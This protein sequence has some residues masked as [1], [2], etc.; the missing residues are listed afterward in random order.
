MSSSYF[1]LSDDEQKIIL[2]RVAAETGV[3]SSVVEKDIYVCWCLEQLF[4]LPSDFP[5]L[6]FKGG[7]SLSK[8]FNAIHRFS[9]DVDITVDQT[10]FLKGDNT[11]NEG[12]SKTKRTKLLEYLDTAV[13]TFAKEMLVPALNEGGST[14]PKKVTALYSKHQTVYVEYPTVTS[15]ELYLVKRVLIELGGR[16]VLQPCSE[17]NVSTIASQYFPAI[18]FP[19]SNVM[20]LDLKRTFWE[21]ATILHS[22]YHRPEPRAGERLSRHWYDTAMLFQNELGKVAARDLEMLSEVARFKEQNYPSS[23]ASYS[24]AKENTL[25]LKPHEKLSLIL[26]ADYEEMIRAGYFYTT[27]LSWS[28]IIEILKEIEEFINR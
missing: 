9:E 13:D 3:S 6:V 24:T 2:N 10:Y 27:P 14:L 12:L 1:S 16:N 5:K 22:E 20:V 25:R 23:W 17:Y 8:I 26:Q 15:T 18:Q 4:S 21:K 19:Q 28:A 11:L 7:T